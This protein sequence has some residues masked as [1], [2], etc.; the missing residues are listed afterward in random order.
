MDVLMLSRLQFAVATFF[1]FIFVPLTLGLSVLLAIM[2]TRYVMTGDETY[3][4]MAKFW[5]KLFLIN[6]ALGVVTGITL[7]FQFGTNWSRYSEYVGDIFGSLL[8]I[9]ATAAFFLESTFIAVWV[10]GW[11]RLSAKMH[12]VAIWLVAIASNLSAVWII[13]A[14]GFMQH[15]VGYVIRNGRAEL[16]DFMEV[17]TNIFA[18]NQFLHTIFGAYL[19]AGF[20]VMGIS[21]WH[22][23]RKQNIDFFTKSFRIGMWFGLIF[24]ILVA[25]Q[26]HHHGNEVAQIQPAKLA[27]M[28]SH[29][30]TQTY[31]PMY[32]LVMPDEENETNSI[33]LLGIPGMLSILAYNNPAAEVKGLKDFPKEDRPP[34]LLTFLSFRLMVGLGTLFPLLGIW[35]FIKRKKLMENPLLLRVMMYAIPLPYLALEAGWALAE[36]GRQP[37]IVYGLMRTSDAVSPIDPSQVTMTLIAFI[38]VY[39][40]LGALDI[41]L[42]AKYAKKG[43][44]EAKA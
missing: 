9:E 18:W 16:A 15:P 8:A 1:H 10:F 22:L 32:L 37:W 35:A 4:R 3:K 27:A 44:E 14:N 38:L 20:F 17:V 26:G 13:L 28:E 30:E 40:L 5:G 7:E 42:L 11:E 34:V 21:A 43:P 29:W 24:S 12:C 33:Q 2:E 39:G 25:V 19:L 41:F 31:A 6:F 36:I 23:L